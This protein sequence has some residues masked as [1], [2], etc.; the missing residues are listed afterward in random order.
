MKFGFAP[1]VSLASLIL[2][3]AA[4]SPAQNASARKP[5]SLPPISKETR[6]ELIHTFQDEL[7]FIRT[8]FPMGKTGLTLKDGMVSP[9]GADLQRM[10]AL[11]GPAMR[12]GDEA[13]LSAV[14]VSNNKIHFEINGGPIRKKKWYQHI[15]VGAGGSTAPI[16][17]SN[18][19]AN[20][21]GSYVDL[22]FDHYVPDL[23][24]QQLKLLLRP[25]F[26]FDAKSAEEAYLDTLPPK[27]KDAI[28]NHNV[29]VGMNREMVLYAKGRPPKKDREKDGEAEYEEWI[30]GTPP[31]DVDFVRF[32]GDEVVRVETMKVDG[33]KIVRT[34]KEIEMAPKPAVADAAR[35]ANAPSL[36]RPGEEVPNDSPDAPR[37][38][39][40]SPQPVPAPPPPPTGPG[41]SFAANHPAF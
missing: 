36:R 38:T 17:P 33:Q 14:T 23:K 31:E 6:L 10:I 21:H 30:Y 20:P 40:P 32:V 7:I 41:P 37:S 19:S 28:K 5:A 18:P 27:L 15:E 3:M 35:P 11:Y 16:A 34:E 25:V 4:A 2:L 39:S 26:D 12:P 24:P 1:S 29:L 13:H 22:V 8:Q 9:S